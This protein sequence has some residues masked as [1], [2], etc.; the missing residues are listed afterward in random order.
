MNSEMSH[1]DVEH[2][3]GKGGHF[4]LVPEQDVHVGQN[5]RE[6]FLEILAD[7][8]S[9]DV[10]TEGTIVLVGEFGNAARTLR[11]DQEEETLKDSSS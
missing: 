10:E 9:G 4:L 5:L 6:L 11:T 2:V 8:Q 1:L 7:V 3:L